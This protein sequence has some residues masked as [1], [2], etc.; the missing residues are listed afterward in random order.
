MTCNSSA[1]PSLLFGVI[2]CL[3]ISVQ[4]CHR[5]P[6]LKSSLGCCNN[7]TARFNQVFWFLGL[8]II[9]NLYT[10][11]AEMIGIQRQ[12]CENGSQCKKHMKT[13]SMEINQ[14]KD[15]E[16]T[17]KPLSFCTFFVKEINAWVRFPF[18]I[19]L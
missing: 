14:R 17:V 8:H 9:F 15:I 4:P 11:L 3:L 19:N 5:K 16:M 13:G 6:L 10:K 12:I 2:I 7:L 1:S 18:Q